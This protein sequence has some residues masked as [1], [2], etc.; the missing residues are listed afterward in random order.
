M[1]LAAVDVETTGTEPLEDRVVE[2]AI[3]EVE[4]AFPSE[5]VVE[6]RT[7]EPWV[8][9]VNPERPIPAAA[10]E[11]H[12]ITDEMVADA[13][14][15]RELADEVAGR[16]ADRVLVGFNHR[17]F[18]VLIL[19]AE[20]RRAGNG[21]L[22][23]FAIEEIDALRVEQVLNPRDLDALAARY[24]VEVDEEARHSAA[25]DAL[26]ATALVFKLASVYGKALDELVA[27]S[28]PE[29]ELDRLR[30]FVRDEE[31]RIR[32]NFGKHRGELAADQ[33]GYLRWMLDRDFAPDT[34]GIARHVLREL[35]RRE[36]GGDEEGE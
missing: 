17:R 5:T 11:V 20:L 19:D 26:L 16:L 1:N 21:G 22:P 25:G 30:R 36:E 27:I 29:D 2:V 28:K 12:G 14:T 18:D 13:P 34:L 35:R 4:E 15:F 23:L 3:V 31:N 6:Y 7:K 9:L 8:A 33:P 10:T 32:F 24:G